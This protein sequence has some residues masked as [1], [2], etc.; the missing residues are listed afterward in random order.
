MA[1]STRLVF[2]TS[3]KVKRAG[4]PALLTESSFRPYLLHP[5]IRLK[6][7]H[8]ERRPTKIPVWID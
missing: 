4:S 2:P 5:L 7:H 6:A 3:T 8:L 1:P